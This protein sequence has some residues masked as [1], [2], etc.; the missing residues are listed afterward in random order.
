MKNLKKI[1]IVLSCVLFLFSCENEDNENL[2]F[3]NT[4]YRIGLWVTPDKKDTLNFINSSSVIRKGLYYEYEEYSY[5]IEN[6]TLFI[7]IP[8]TES[9]SQ[10]LILEIENDKVTLG[11][12]YITTEVSD[13]SGS[14]IKQ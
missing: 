4:D 13:N 7:S 9:Q 11:N 1:F 5:E 2:N 8:E 6:N 3:Y 10:H 12:M 14:F